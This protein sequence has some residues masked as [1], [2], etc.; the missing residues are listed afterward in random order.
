MISVMREDKAG[1]QLFTRKVGNQGAEW[2]KETDLVFRGARAF[3]SR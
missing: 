1:M 2:A 3:I